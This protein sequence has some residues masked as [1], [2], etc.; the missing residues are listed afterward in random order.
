LRH[1]EKKTLISHQNRRWK[2]FA[3]KVEKLTSENVVFD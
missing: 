3:E 1:N 2:I